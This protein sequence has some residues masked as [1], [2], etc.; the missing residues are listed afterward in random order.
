MKKSKCYFVVSPFPFTSLWFASTAFFKENMW[1]L[2]SNSLILWSEEKKSRITGNKDFNWCGWKKK[3]KSS[4]LKISTFTSVN[5]S[6]LKTNRKNVHVN[7]N[8]F[9]DLPILV[10]ENSG[11]LFKSFFWHCGKSSAFHNAI[12]FSPFLLLFL[13][14]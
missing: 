5:C 11:R 3:I 13:R 6:L 8:H 2:C 4:L 12:N 1:A 14:T 7:V 9:D 10:E